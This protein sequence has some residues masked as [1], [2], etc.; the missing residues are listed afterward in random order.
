MKKIKVA[1]LGFGNRGQM[2][3][4]FI[5]N[6]ENVE[7]AAIAD[8]VEVERRK[9]IDKYGLKEEDCY[10]SAEDFLSERRDIDALFICTQ[11]KDHREHTIRALELGYDICLEKPIAA[12][13]EDCLAIQECAKRA[14]RKVMICHVLRYSHFYQ[15]IKQY[16]LEGKLG[17][18]V[19]INQT[20][21]VAYWHAAHSYVR[22]AWRNS[23]ESSPMILAKCCHDIDILCWLMDKQVKS[24]SSF[25]D[26]YYFKE[27]MAPE[28][29]AAFCVDCNEKTKAACPYDAFKIYHNNNRIIMGNNSLIYGKPSNDVDEILSSRANRFGRCVFRCDNDVV[30]HQVVNLLFENNLTAHL[31]MISFSAECFRSIKVHGTL[32][33]IY[34]N[35]EE[36]CLYYQRYGQ[37]LEKIDLTEKHDDFSIHGGGDIGLY[38]DFINYLRDDSPSITRTTLDASIESHVVCFLAEESRIKGGTSIDL[39]GKFC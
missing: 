13:M 15:T 1:I 38:R 31:T 37:P 9:G 36:N 14:Q 3:A 16:I 17:D 27:E 21:N 28:G 19:T 8:P 39:R 35:M 11:D 24:V 25:G 20:E 30:D 4:D 5:L 34:G 26:L 18:V 32:G 22:G 10:L 29:S 23:A 12:T 33:E 7:L 2:F 6:D